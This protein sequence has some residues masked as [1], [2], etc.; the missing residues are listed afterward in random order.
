M[1]K[2]VLLRCLFGA[3]LGLAIGTVITIIISLT[4]GDG[5]YYAVVPELIQDCGSEINAV[6][7]QSVLSLIYGA[8][9]A[10]ASVIWENERWSIL[11]QTVIHLII[12][13]AATFPIAY[14][15]RWMP[16]NLNGVLLYF[17]IFVAIYIVIWFS[18]YSSM[19][20]KVQ[21]INERL[22]KKSE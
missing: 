19:K 12:C 3:P 1:L 7:F 6:V 14:F 5:V 2:K 18:Q 20:K 11:K 15:A 17:G 16:H 22:N 13:S 8:A 10:G 4:V 9:W 21:Q